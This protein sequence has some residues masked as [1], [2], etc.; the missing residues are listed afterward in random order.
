MDR[1]KTWPHLAIIGLL[2][3]VLGV[4]AAVLWVRHEQTA[5]ASALPNAARID[6][7]NGEVALNRGLDSS[8]SNTQWVNAEQNTPI[9]VGDR[10][11][12]K[13]NADASVS[14]TG[15][16]FARLNADTSLDVLTMADD[17]TQLALRDGSAVFDIGALPSGDLFEVATPCGAVDLNEPGLYQIEVNDD[18]NATATAL[19]GVAQVVGQ[20]GTGR[21]EKGEVLDVPCNGSAPATLSRVEPRAAGT[22][23][24]RYYRYR[25]PRNYDGRYVNY[26]SYLSDPSYY[27]PSR[28][29][30]SY[31]YVSDYIPGVDDLDYYGDWQEVSNYGQC[32]RPRV[33]NG[34]A[35]YQSGYWTTDYPYGLTWVSNEP[36]GY[37]PYHYGR[38]ASVSNQWFWVPDRARTRPAYSPALVAFIPLQ[39]ET[40]GWVPLAPGDPYAPRYYDSNWTPRY[41][42]RTR[43]VQDR[44]INLNVPGAV[45]VVNVR[46]FNRVIDRRTIERVDA[47]QLAHVRPVLDPYAVR[48]FRDVALRTRGAERRFDLSPQV[49]QRIDRP[50]VTSTTPVTPFRRDLAQRFHVRPVPEKVRGERLQFRDNRQSATAAQQSPNQANPN[51]SNIAAEQARERQMADLSREAARGNRAARQ[52][53]QQL[54]RQQRQEQQ[55][56]R[57]QVTAQQRAQ[58]M[59]TQQA[60]G[61]RVSNSMQKQKGVDQ[62]KQR[63]QPPATVQPPRENRGGRYIKGGTTQPRANPQ[64]APMNQQP[65]RQRRQESAPRQVQRQQAQ[66]RERTLSPNNQPANRARQP[67]QARPQAAPQPRPMREQRQPQ[68][69][70]QAQPQQRS[71]PQ[72]QRQPA[73]VRQQPQQQQQQQKSERRPPTQAAPA[74]AAAQPQNK[75]GREHP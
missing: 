9:S 24:D 5:Q 60:Q 59:A 19:S 26:D 7:V 71:Q 6:R 52:Q 8:T 22:L 54:Q 39:T 36:W 27:D 41:T 32:W 18:G 20:G 28:R 53:V 30:A 74:P 67:Q 62:L 61:E 56:Q 55:Q 38:W 73:P 69:Q 15:R 34:W 16:N 23:V 70:R 42:S 46:D 1:F 10:I 33:D 63:S 58:R 13:E 37:A 68:P 31:Q 49:T 3:L 64:P 50:V 17:K 4:G 29:F 72:V 65:A 35:P 21:I 66:P 75:K 47:Q 51:Q 48:N 43:V 11:Y 57:E 25:Y 40:I 14:F 2:C 12:T 44:V 45:T